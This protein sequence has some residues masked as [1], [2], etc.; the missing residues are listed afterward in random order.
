MPAPTTTTDVYPTRYAAFDRP[1]E[2]VRF[3]PAPDGT[4]RHC[5]EDAERRPV[6]VLSLPVKECIVFHRPRPDRPQ[7]GGRDGYDYAEATP[8]RP[9][10]CWVEFQRD[11]TGRRVRCADL[12]EAERLIRRMADEDWFPPAPPPEVTRG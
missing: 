10:G 1:G 4:F 5:R 12:D 2:I 8:R 3:T 11:G 6:T 9:S 7:P